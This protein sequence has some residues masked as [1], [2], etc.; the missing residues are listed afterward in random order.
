[1]SAK[2]KGRAKKIRGL[3]VSQVIKLIQF[4]RE[5]KL[6]PGRLSTTWLLLTLTQ[7]RTK[8]SMAT[9]FNLCLLWFKTFRAVA[10]ISVGQVISRL[11]M[12]Q[13]GRLIDA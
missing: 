7:P 3:C 8:A 6:F 1:M 10:Q 13:G 9:Q 4:K 12:M 5:T 11:L 2:F